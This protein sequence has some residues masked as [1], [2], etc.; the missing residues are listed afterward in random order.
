MR[1]YLEHVFMKRNLVFRSFCMFSA[2]FVVHIQ[3]ALTPA[4]AAQKP[5]SIAAIPEPDGFHRIKNE[6]DSFG[7]FLRS[8]PL[9]D[10]A[11]I[12]SFT[13]APIDASR[14]KLLCV[15]DIKL[16]FKK[17][18]EQCAD[19]AMRLWAEYHRSA[20][21]LNTLYLFN[22]SGSK[23]YFRTS[24]KTYSQ[25]LEK[26]LIATNSYSLKKGCRAVNEE[27][28]MPGDMF[29]QNE[30]GGIGHV[31]MILDACE[32]SKGQ[33]LYLVGFS[34]MPAQE[35]HVEKGSGEYGK[36]GWFSRDGY[37]AYLNRYYPYGK[38][39]VRRFETGE[40]GK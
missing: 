13:G 20:N 25:F 6:K 24:G 10:S 9:R 19:W 22:Y 8:L 33:R 30:N 31:S 21:K 37:M 36:L 16:L 29:V 1:I 2:L 12:K 27:K 5:V 32:N 15:I 17:D 11:I 38:P 34:F 28:L 4:L 14:Y 35:F 40:S 23:T 3:E 18:I 39:V 26:A 7:S